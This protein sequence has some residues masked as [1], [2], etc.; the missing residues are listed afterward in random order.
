M[1]GLDS[2]NNHWDS[3]IINQIAVTGDVWMRQPNQPLVT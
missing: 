3:K 2:A 1:L